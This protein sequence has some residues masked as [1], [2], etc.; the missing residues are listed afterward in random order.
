MLIKSLHF[1][2][3]F[4]RT[5]RTRRILSIALLAVGCAA[6]ASCVLLVPGSGLPDFVQSFYLGAGCG[7]VACAILFLIRIQYLIRHP[8]AWKKARIREED[9]REQAI[10]N[11][12][13]RSA[14]LFT[15]FAAAA[16]LFLILPFSTTAFFA[17][18][19]VIVVYFLAMLCFRAYFSRAL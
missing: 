10:R 18:L 1:S 7:L 3:N 2:G 19:A 6:L 13:F 5:L 11:R 16:A 9:E 4:E 17:L 15:F 14:G 12:A 8:E